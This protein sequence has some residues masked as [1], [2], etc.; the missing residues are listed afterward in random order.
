MTRTGENVRP[1]Q[2]EDP[3]RPIL[4]LLTSSAIVAIKVIQSGSLPNQELQRLKAVLSNH[5]VMKFCLLFSQ[6]RAL[7]PP[8]PNPVASDWL[9]GPSSSTHP[10]QA[11]SRWD[12]VG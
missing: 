8:F 4:K 12:E 1:A 6:V 9:S 2:L 7:P 10:S 3:S 5:K 11:S